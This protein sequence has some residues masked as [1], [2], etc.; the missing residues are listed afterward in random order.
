M[1]NCEDGWI[2]R[3]FFVYY[4]NMIFFQ[5]QY[6]KNYPLLHFISYKYSVWD[7]LSFYVNNDIYFRFIKTLYLHPF[8]ALL[9][10]KHDV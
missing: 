1:Q 3:K 7:H 9:L 8:S 5:E 10:G 6:F 2:K 4:S